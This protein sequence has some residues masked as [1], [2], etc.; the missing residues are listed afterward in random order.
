MCIRDS[1]A[2]KAEALGKAGL[3]LLAG[4]AAA[5][6]VATSTQD[7]D[8]GITL[9]RWRW[10]PAS[11]PELTLNA[12][13]QVR[14]GRAV[15]YDLAPV[16]DPDL[17][18]TV[19]RRPLLEEAFMVLLLLAG[20]IYLLYTLRYYQP[21]R[22]AFLVG[23]VVALLL[24]GWVLLTL[25]HR[26]FF[27]DSAVGAFFGALFTPI[28]HHGLVAALLFGAGY[29]ALRYACPWPLEG[30]EL[31]LQGR[32]RARPVAL[33]LRNG[34]LAGIPLALA[35]YLVAAVWPGFVPFGLGE[36]VLAARWPAVA[37]LWPR[38]GLSLIHI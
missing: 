35:P 26:F 7:G 34:V 10:Q 31:L 14:G 19:G 30:L 8:E 32:W 22:R 23:G 18:R 9:Y 5:E 13:V 33:G 1:P 27:A 6:F 36:E 3:G 38:I 28:C 21:H 16:V 11:D 37:V 17:L 12:R 25:R 4:P 24:F 15:V 29:V 20:A 2:A